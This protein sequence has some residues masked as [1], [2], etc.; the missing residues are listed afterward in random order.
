MATLAGNRDF[1]LVLV[2]Q[3]LSA[4]GS[5]MS[6]TALP[7]VVASLT[8]SGFQLGLVGALEALPA[9]ALCL[10]AGAL[11]DRWDRRKVMIYSDLASALL[12]GMLPLAV[13]LE[14]PLMPVVYLV[15]APLGVLGVLFVA[16]Y[17]AALLELVGREHVGAANAYHQVVVTLGAVLGPSAAGYMLGRF[18]IAT[19]LLVDTISFV[20]AALATGIG[21]RSLNA[22]RHA[23]PSVKDDIVEALRFVAAAPLMRVLIP[24]YALVVLISA[25][26]VA[27]VTFSVAIEQGGSEAEFGLLLSAFSVGN[28]AGYGLASQMTRGRLGRLMLAANFAFGLMLLAF[29]I[30]PPGMARAVACGLAGLCSALTHIPYVTLRTLHT[31]DA[32]IA[33]VGSTARMLHLGAQPIGLVVGGL[34]IDHASGTST[35]ALMGALSL[36]LSSGFAASRAMR[37]TRASEPC[38]TGGES[39]A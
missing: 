26:L 25:P 3:G 31:P 19:T 8:H 1:K 18:G 32:M 24:F 28:V 34:W 13:L 29:T 4:F 7:L 16:A 11:A 15:A 10:V 21:R 36:L 39:H 38:E 30:A 14:L 22:A 37:D 5:A 2:G 33:R 27:A 12:T 6:L 9:F 20:V 23:L 35:L 17:S